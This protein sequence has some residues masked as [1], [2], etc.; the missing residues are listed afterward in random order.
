MDLRR[1]REFSW[2]HMS[3]PANTPVPL[4]SS[5]AN[6]LAAPVAVNPPPPTLTVVPGY[7]ADDALMSYAAQLGLSKDLKL[8]EVP[9]A[10]VA[11]PGS[12]TAEVAA[13]VVPGSV[14]PATTPPANETPEAKIAR[15]EA[16]LVTAKAGNNLAADGTP[17]A[18]ELAAP[19]GSPAQPAVPIQA[20]S[21]ENPL[22]N[23]RTP[24]AFTAAQTAASALKAWSIQHPEGGELPAQ[25]AQL[26]ENAEAHRTGRAPGTVQ[27]VAVAIDADMARRIHANAEQLLDLHLP[28]RQQFVQREN[29]AVQFVREQAPEMF[30]A[31]KPEST[32][33]K[34]FIA[35]YP[36]LLQIDHWP[37]IIRDLVKGHIA[38]GVQTP[39]PA[40]A[41]GAPALPANVVPLEQGKTVP[42]APIAPLGGGGSAAPPISQQRIDAA[43]ERL[44]A[45]TYTDDDLTILGAAAV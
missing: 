16:E 5:V 34:G 42:L 26:A 8:P 3:T 43:Q 25:L 21:P 38:N 29:R 32:L 12:Q 1:K 36:Q 23:L 10:A 30:D 24:D 31:A 7:E 15:L 40:A 37:L 13:A 45:G 11:A 39:A 35:N 4:A 44:N 22:V 17:K 27:P 20:P 33:F 9:A 18:G 14:T 41:G 6:V 2:A 19:G 28:A